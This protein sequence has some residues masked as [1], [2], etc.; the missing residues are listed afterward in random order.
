MLTIRNVPF[1]YDKQKAIVAVNWLEIIVFENFQT[2]GT[3]LSFIKICES[4]SWNNPLPQYVSMG[5]HL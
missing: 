4:C 3:Q 5:Y 2:D 1:C